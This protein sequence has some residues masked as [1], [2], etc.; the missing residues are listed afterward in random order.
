MNVWTAT[1]SPTYVIVTSTPTPENVFTIVPSAATATHVAAT[2]GTY[3]PVPENWVT[4]IVV[5]PVPTPANTAT[6]AYQDALAT[7]EAI[8]FGTPTPTPMNVW[9]VT[10]TPIFVLLDGEIP[11]PGPTPTPTATPRPI[12]SELV[13]KIAFLSNRAGG[14]E[15]LVYVI[16]PDGSNLA[17]L[18][19]RW[20]YDLARE[21]DA[22]SADKRFRVFTKNVIRYRNVTGEQV[23]KEE[24]PALFWYDAYYKVEEQLTYFGSGIAYL[25]V[26]SP[27]SE[28]I[29]FVS[30]DSG[31]DEI[32]VIN[33]DGSNLRQLTESNMEY[34]ADE[35]GK[36]TFIPEVNRHPS[37]SPDGSKIVFWSNRTGNGQIWVMDADGNNLYSLS[38]TSFGDWDPVWIKY[39]DP[40]PDPT[41]VE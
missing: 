27:T 16:E 24:V 30:N 21:R 34:N 13:G 8:V 5:T 31:D 15:P 6:A 38:R 2:I 14:E 12:P 7:T 39:T 9:T 23:V 33:R 22:Y 19:D 32:W 41:Q 36:D 25:G 10:P 1:P 20:P 17:L 18:T 4:P 3:T 35:I 37:W 11:T 40:P 28:Q 26:W 29:A